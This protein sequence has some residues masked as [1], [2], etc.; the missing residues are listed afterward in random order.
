MSLKHGILGL[1]NYGAMS[2]YDLTKAFNQS[3]NLFWSA[4]TSQIY[5]ELETMAA[6]NWIE[7]KEERQR[8]HMVTTIYTITSKGRSELTR[9][10]LEPLEKRER[11]RNSFLLRFFFL[12]SKGAE[13]IRALV[14]SCKK[15]AEANAEALRETINNVIPER[16]KAVENDL[17]V[18]CWSQAAEFGLAQYEAEARWAENCLAQLD[19]LKG[20]KE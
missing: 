13:P 4:Q 16:R 20:E 1:L 18:F 10:L 17:T 3:L 2:G 5:R 6:S 15:R 9:W 12:S 8:G 7:V 19:A 11:N 14:G